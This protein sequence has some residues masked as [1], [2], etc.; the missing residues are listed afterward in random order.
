MDNKKVQW[1]IKKHE[2]SDD[3]LKIN[4]GEIEY[5]CNQ[6]EASITHALLL[7]FDT[8]VNY[9]EN[10]FIECQ[11]CGGNVKTCECEV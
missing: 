11:Y 3:C 4:I 6:D 8:L 7:I 10:E 1:T 2:T 9:N 5:T